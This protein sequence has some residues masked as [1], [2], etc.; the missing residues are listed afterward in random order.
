MNNTGDIEW[1]K[2]LG[3]SKVDGASS[4]Q[5][6]TDSGYIIAGSTSSYNG[7]VT[8]NHATDKY[9]CWIVKLSSIGDIQWQKT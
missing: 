3:G 8:G 6:T 1:K 4:I 5:Q 2:S 9:D 7:D